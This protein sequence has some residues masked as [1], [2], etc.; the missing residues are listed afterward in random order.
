MESDSECMRTAV[1]LEELVE[2]EYGEGSSMG[3]SIIFQ[4]GRGWCE[5]AWA[6]EQGRGGGCVGKGAAGGAGGG[7]VQECGTRKLC[8]RKRLA[9]LHPRSN[10]SAH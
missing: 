1:L 5:R 3:P 2:A 10:C 9:A 4:V 8:N 7:R 6:G